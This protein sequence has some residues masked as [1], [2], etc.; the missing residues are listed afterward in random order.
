[1]LIAFVIVG[2]AFAYAVLSMG[3]S[4]TQ[5]SQQVVLGGLQA[6]S[7]LAVDGP[8]YGYS[9]QTGPNAN[10]TSLILWVK[11]VAGAD[12]IDLSVNRTTLGFQNPRGYWMNIYNSGG[13]QLTYTLSGTTYIVSSSATT[14]VWETGQGMILTAGQK[15]RVTIDLT[16]IHIGGAANTSGQLAK[17]EEFKLLFKT[18]TGAMLNIQRT[19]PGQVTLVNELG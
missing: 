14:I 11:T 12:P 3:S 13:S 17:S 19:A 8:V 9:T 10:M 2:S 18:A 15:A 4:A 5:K 6:D 7:A 1:V 16:Q